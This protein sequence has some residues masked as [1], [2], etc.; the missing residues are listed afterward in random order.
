MVDSVHILL[1]AGHH[2]H[3]V[4]M[5]PWLTSLHYM[6]PSDSAI[7]FDCSAMDAVA[8]LASVEVHVALVACMVDTSSDRDVARAVVH[9]DSVDL[10]VDAFPAMKMNRK[11]VIIQLL[12]AVICFFFVQM[13]DFTYWLRW[14]WLRLI[15]H[16]L[17]GHRLWWSLWHIHWG[18][19]LRIWRWWPEEL[20]WDIVWRWWLS[21]TKDEQ[22]LLDTME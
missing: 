20:H 4:P 14:T 15:P 17:V 11:L 3:D 22:S 5:F 2:V 16:I 10:V 13:R 12:E 9:A 8:A 19:T 18:C 1:A 6:R 21:K 7:A